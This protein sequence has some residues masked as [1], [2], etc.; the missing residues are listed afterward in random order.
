VTAADVERHV[1]VA[2]AALGLDAEPIDAS[3]GELEALLRS[4]GPAVLRISTPSPAHEG[5]GYAGGDALVMLVGRRGRRVRVVGPDQRIVTVPVDLLRRALS[6]PQEAPLVAETERLV[7]DAGV[8]HR[9]RAAVVRAL[10]GDRL[11]ARRLQAGW[12]L[13]MPPGS[14]F[15][16]QLAAAGAHRQ[17]V[18]L[19][20]LHAAQYGLWIAAW[21][22][23]GLAALQGHLDSAWLGAWM[24]ALF[25]LIPLQLAA[26]WLQGRLAISAGALVKQRLLAGAF[27]LEPEEIRTEGAG[28]LLGRVIEAQA[29]ESLALSGGFLALLAA[30]ELMMAAGVLAVATPLL[31]LLLLVWTGLAAALAAVFFGRRLA[32]VRLRLGLTLDLIEGMVGHRTRIAQQARDDWHAGEDDALERYVHASAAMDRASVWLLAV[33]PRGWMLVGLCGLAPLFVTG[34]SPALLAVGLGGILL[35]FRA[36]DRLTNGLWSLAGA[37]IAGRQIAP[38]FRAAERDAADT[39]AAPASPSATPPA[40]ATLDATDLRFTHQHRGEPVLQGC[41]M[42]VAPGDRIVLQGPSGG[43]KSTLAS[44]LAGL[45]TPQSGLLLLDGADRHTLGLNGWRRRVVL[46][47]QFHENHLVLGSVALNVLMGVG[48][49]PAAEDF[50]RAERVLRELGLGDTLDR[51]PSGLL[52]TIGETGWQLSHGERSRI[53]LARALLQHPDV[54]I[55]DESFAQLDAENMQRALNAVSARAPAVLLIAHP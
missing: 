27:R 48:W 34:G 15:R 3:C 29:V 54:L 42:T 51:M 8:H 17:L 50:E 14:S 43:G 30:L 40:P 44:L 53:F 31:A 37:A 12:L 16:S 22:L 24:L 36:L 21:W 11:R 52:Q 32:W 20:A 4:A 46:V 28:H 6:G 5:H 9:R 7:E 23:L 26:L 2:A 55:L 49:P 25:S 19:A 10:V 38:V 18:L 41:S 1:P 47:P 33:V 39:A 35:A 45:R 13:R